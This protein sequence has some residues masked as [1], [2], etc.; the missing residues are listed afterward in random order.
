VSGQGTFLNV[1][2]KDAD[3]AWRYSRAIW[4]SSGGRAP[5][6]TRD[7]SAIRETISAVEATLNARDFAGYA[8]TFAEEADVIFYG[9]SR[10]SGR[11]AIQDEM[12][13]AWKTQPASCRVALKVDAVRF[14]S[15]DLALVDAPAI[16]SGCKGWSKNGGTSVMQRV[17]DHWQSAGLRIARLSS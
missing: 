13:K 5:D 8:Q 11:A 9:G 6:R 3:G 12:V 4:N 16:F 14:L 10:L 17:G 15:S 7:E 1:L 2:R